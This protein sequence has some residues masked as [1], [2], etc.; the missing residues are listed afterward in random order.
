MADV[1]TNGKLITDEE[2]KDQGTDASGPVTTP[3]ETAGTSGLITGG[4]GGLANGA[5][6]GG[7]GSWTNIQ[8]Y[9]SANKGGTGSE[10]IVQDKVGG[11]FGTEKQALEKAGAD[12][13][14]AAETQV[15]GIK[16]TADGARNTINEAAN[17][18][19]WGAETQDDNYSQKTGGLKS[20]LSSKYSG[21]TSFDYSMSNDAQKY[22][23]ALGDDRAF[24]SLMDDFYRTAAGGQISRGGL[25][26]Q[27]QLDTS[28][29]ALAK[30]RGDLLK[31]Y[32]GLK[33]LRDTTATDVGNFLKTAQED[34]GKEQ[35]RLRDD[36]GLYG[37]ENDTATSLL[38]DTARQGFDNT[39]RLSPTGFDLGNQFQGYFQ[40]A[41]FEQ[42][43]NEV[44]RILNMG[45]G[46]YW[47]DNK[48]QIMGMGP[49]EG[50]VPNFMREA[51]P[52]LNSY[53][54]REAQKY[55]DTADTEKRRFNAIMD[56]LGVNSAK[57]Q[58][59]VPGRRFVRDDIRQTI[60]NRYGIGSGKK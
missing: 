19:Q 59:F 4:S 18:Y 31:E 53:Y 17:A 39:Y 54:S 56:V 44:D 16:D 5:R 55:G 47:R 43:Q 7:A 21:P 11:Q 32:S 37:N 23:T 29:D 28:N 6:P 20:A 50:A 48:D 2:E 41:T 15:K 26:L 52:L 1:L 13:R 24:G 9:L 33:S 46:A 57:E 12:T 38:E 3:S 40:N 22:G 14:S 36:L 51:I 10:K 35:T 58:G 42:L 27:R 30:T 60:E 49:L 8:S 25:D 45:G 34:F